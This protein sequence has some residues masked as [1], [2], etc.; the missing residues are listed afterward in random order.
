MSHTQNML[1]IEVH[2]HTQ[3]GRVSDSP[4]YFINYTNLAAPT[5]PVRGRILRGRYLSW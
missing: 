5:S 3:G 4:A 2:S 1:D